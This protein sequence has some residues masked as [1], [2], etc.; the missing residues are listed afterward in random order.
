IDLLEQ[1]LSSLKGPAEIFLCGD[2]QFLQKGAAI[3][4]HRKL[5]AWVS[6]EHRMGCAVGACMGCAIRVR[7]TARY[8][9][10]CTEGPVFPA[11]EVVW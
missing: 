4:R 11:S 9:R 6:L 2:Q 7:S 1:T 8:A 10:V 5:P 3:A